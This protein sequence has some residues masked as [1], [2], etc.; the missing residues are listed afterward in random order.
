MVKRVPEFIQCA[1]KRVL[2]SGSII[3]NI[4]KVNRRRGGKPTIDSGI[5]L[6]WLAQIV[7]RTCSYHPFFSMLELLD[8]IFSSFYPDPVRNTKPCNPWMMFA[9]IFEALGMIQNG[10]DILD[11]NETKAADLPLHVLICQRGISSSRTPS[12]AY[13]GHHCSFKTL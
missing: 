2:L 8:L 4:G 10:K 13:S 12:L 6:H 9:T 3:S 1:F 11:S 7:A 5:L